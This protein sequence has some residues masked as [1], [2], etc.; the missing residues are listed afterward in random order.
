MS[1]LQENL[2]K[3]ETYLARFRQTGVLNRIAGEDT[4]AADGATFETVSP[5]DLKPLATVAK[6][7]AADIDRAAK[8]A[9]TAFA[10]WATM[11]GDVLVVDVVDLRQVRDVWD[12]LVVQGGDD[13]GN[14]PLEAVAKHAEGHV[15]AGVPAPAWAIP[16]PG[17]GVWRKTAMGIRR[18]LT[19]SLGRSQQASCC[20]VTPS[21]SKV[22]VMRRT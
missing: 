14:D 9:K 3:A 7:T 4:A 19:R 17:P 15:H 11:P 10:D 20:A 22:C 16:A 2:A 1:K 8:A 13:R 18:S 12:A 6:G 5:V 21:S